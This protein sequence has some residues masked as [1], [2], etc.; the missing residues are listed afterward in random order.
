MNYGTYN[1]EDNGERER[2]LGKIVFL[3]CF[4]VFRERGSREIVFFRV[5]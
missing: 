1:K 4:R 2:G 5:F 3:G